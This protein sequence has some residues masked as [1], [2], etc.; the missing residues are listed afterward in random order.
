MSPPS[1]ASRS[2]LEG[3]QTSDGPFFPHFPCLQTLGTHTQTV[4]Q[5]LSRPHGSSPVDEGPGTKRRVKV[6]EGPLTRVPLTRVSYRDR[7]NPSD[8]SWGSGALDLTT[9]RTSDPHQC[10]TNHENL[11]PQTFSFYDS[12]PPL[13]RSTPRTPGETRSQDR[14]STPTAS[15][16]TRHSGHGATGD[17]SPGALHTYTRTWKSPR[18]RRGV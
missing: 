1:R 6:V 7:T 8:P 3:I 14:H 10:G 9:P 17:E 4:S 2:G 11:P 18:E 16:P 13:P 12:R 5:T 15:V